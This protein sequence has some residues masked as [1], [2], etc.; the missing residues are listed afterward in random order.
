M[1]GYGWICVGN[2][3][4]WVWVGVCII[5]VN[6]CFDWYGMVLEF[7]IYRVLFIVDNII[8]LG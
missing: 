1:E 5:N 3:G 8:V 6:C 7:W 2:V 4:V